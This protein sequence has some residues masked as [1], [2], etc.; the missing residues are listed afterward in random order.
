MLREK[1][2]PLVATAYCTHSTSS[3]AC[4]TLCH[5]ACTT[6]CRTN[7]HAC[8]VPLQADA[9]KPSPG[10]EYTFARKQAAND[11]NRC[12]C[13]VAAPAYQCSTLSTA[14]AVWACFTAVADTLAWH[15]PH[16]T[17]SACQADTSVSPTNCRKDIAHVWEL[18]GG[19]ALTAQL[20]QGSHIFLTHRQVGMRVG[21]CHVSVRVCVCVEGTGFRVQGW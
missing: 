3:F 2:E 12:V 1:E 16:M 5:M 4:H 20:I 17:L 19:Q 9:P 6:P 14:L 7:N 13:C 15:D 21:G 11:A 10:L 8:A 18:S